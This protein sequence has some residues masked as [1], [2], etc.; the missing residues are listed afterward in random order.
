MRVARWAGVLVAV[1]CAVALAVAWPASPVRSAHAWLVAAVFAYTVGCGALALLMIGYATDAVWLVVMRRPIEAVAGTLPLA[2]A[3]LVPVL[4]S[5]DALYPWARVPSLPA[6]EAEL[7]RS[8]QA[9]LNEPAFVLRSIGYLAVPALLGELLLRGSRR[10]DRPASMRAQ[11]VAS[12]LGLPVLGLVTSFA[13]FDWLMS[14]EPGF[15][16]TSFGLLPNAGGFLALTGLVAV[17]IAIGRRGALDAVGPEHTHALGKVM[18][19]ALCVWAYL[20][21]THFLILWIADL[22][23]EARWLLPRTTGGWKR[24]ARALIAFHFALPFA[25]LL[26]RELKRRAVLL[27]LVGA[28]VFLVHWLELFWLA[29][30]ALEPAGPTFHVADLASLLGLCSAMLALATLR[31]AGLS[32]VPRSDPLLARALRYRSE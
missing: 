6:H 3:A 24:V 28:L 7:L 4:L 9:W 2:A 8:K 17:V 27:A 25:A 16:S 1:V 11:R 23:H 19:A 5:L 15:Y 21:F 31:V 30:P 14:L 29:L 26:S 12:A 10:E 32:P 13:M 22:P 18:L 20:A